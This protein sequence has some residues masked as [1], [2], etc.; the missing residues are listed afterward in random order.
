[1]VIWSRVAGFLVVG[2][3]SMARSFAY[4]GVP[5][6]FI[7]EAVLAAFLLLKPRVAL[8]TWAMSL[9]RASPLSG[10]GLALLIF[11]L[12][13]LWQM[14]RGVLEGSP[15]LY[16][17]KFFIFNY[18]PLY[19]FLGLWIG[20]QSPDFL[21]KLVRVIAWANGI[22]ALMWLLGLNDVVIPL[23]PMT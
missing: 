20:L 2:Y 10:L 18:Y 12:Y 1:M 14:G 6:I 9:V 23:P 3:L 16:T 7:G 19:L 4:L 15:V 13:G 21:P 11:M 8:G 5:P 17:L 22:Y